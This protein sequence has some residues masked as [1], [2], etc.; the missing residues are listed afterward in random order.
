MDEIRQ[1]QIVEPAAREVDGDGEWKTVVVQACAFHQC[2]RCQDLRQFAHQTLAF[3]HAD[4]GIRREGAAGRMSP[5]RQRLDPH[6][7]EAARVHLGLEP[8]GE[9]VAGDPVAD[10][11]GRDLQRSGKLSPARAWSGRPAEQ[12]GHLR[13]RHRLLY[14]PQH[15]QPLQIGQLACRVQHFLVRAAHQD[16]A[17]LEP[18]TAELTEQF[19]TVHRRHAEVADHGL[20]T[21]VALTQQPQRIQAA[22]GGQDFLDA[23]G[24]KHG[25]HLL[26]HNRVVVD[27]E[28]RAMPGERGTPFWGCDQREGGQPGVDGF[29]LFEGTAQHGKGRLEIALPSA[30]RRGLQ[31]GG[32][33]RIAHRADG[34]GRGLLLVHFLHHRGRGG[35]GGQL[36]EAACRSTEERGDQFAR[37][38]FVAVTQDAVQAGEIEN[39][40]ARCLRRRGRR[41]RSPAEPALQFGAQCFQQDRLG[42]RI[43][44]AGIMAM[45]QLCG[46]VCG[47]DADDRRMPADRCLALAHRA[48]QREAVHHRHVEV[49]QNQFVALACP[50]FKGRGAVGDD[51]GLI[52][53]AGE[54]HPQ[55]DLI[56]GVIFR[57]QY[58]RT[59]L[60]RDAWRR[61]GQAVCAF[62]PGRDREFDP[63]GA[64]V[65][66]RAVDPDAAGHGLDQAACDRE[67]ESRTLDT[68]FFRAETVEG[69][70]Q[71]RLVGGSNSRSIVADGE[72]DA[73]MIN[74]AAKERDLATDTVVFEGVRDQLVENL[75]QCVPVA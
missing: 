47:R 65:A 14:L 44:H 63:E 28:Q 26:L 51:V 41:R 45:P 17:A 69:H 73:V 21:A 48:S 18:R 29:D 16:D 6:R 4:E 39:R 11:L 1:L 15:A 23:Q 13:W 31:G 32:Q 75:E 62:R 58:A 37:L 74:G 27:D 57:H 61:G 25:G 20:Q 60:C 64:A 55:Q 9:F 59:L 30:M 72:T 56:G 49:G 70:K 66:R 22:S 46:M 8:H 24:D 54:L 10:G 71:L 40:V 34:P 36:V 52:A 38:G 12:A 19:D 43:V 42:Q 3:S 67:S 35:A 50:G 33:L 53:E 2:T 7:L 5:A 68:T